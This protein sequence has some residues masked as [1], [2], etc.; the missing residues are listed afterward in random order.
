MRSILGFGIEK[1]I[2]YTSLLLY[3]Q[4]NYIPAPFTILQRVQK[5]MPGHF[6]LIKGDHVEINEYYQ[7]PDPDQGSIISASDPGKEI[8]RILEESVNMRLV[9]DVPL[10]VF[11]SGGIDSSLITAIAS[12]YRENLNTFSIGYSSESYFDET[13]YARQVADYNGTHHHSFRLSRNDLY[14]HLNDI[15]D[16]IDEP[17]ADSSAIPVYILSKLTRKQV[18][19]ALSGDGADEVFSGY[20]KHLAFLRSRG[21]SFKN[22]LIGNSRFFWKLFPQSRNNPLFNAFRQLDRYSRGLNE[23]GPGRYWLWASLM[24]DRQAMRLILE[25]NLTLEA[26]ENIN[27]FKR[28]MTSRISDVYTMNQILYTDMH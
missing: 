8:K 23:T 13:E 27:G 2:D 21:K 10:G 15:L 25:N 3:L 5:L 18:T 11:L 17:F 7:L 26:G 20:N 4:L 28:K 24:E 19:V 1:S 16:H 12:R 22:L 14:D 9:S 6:I